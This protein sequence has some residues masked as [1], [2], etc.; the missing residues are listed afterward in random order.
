[1][2]PWSLL[3]DAIDADPEKPAGLYSAL[4][5]FTQ[6][7]CISFALFFFGNL[8]SLSGYVA[9]HGIMQPGS[10]LL[11][12]R[13]CMGVIPATLVVLGLVVIRRWPE[14]TAQLGQET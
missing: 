8:M 1:L 4:M 14:R 2:I 10:A 12:I 7:I 9:A 13:L 5:V 3:P 11:A 6:K